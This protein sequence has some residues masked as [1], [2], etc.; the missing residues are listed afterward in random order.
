MH[1]LSWIKDLL[2]FPDTF[3]TQVSLEKENLN[4]PA[5][6]IGIAGVLKCISMVILLLTAGD[7]L[8]LLLPTAVIWSLAQPF[9]V[10]VVFSLVLQVLSNRLSGTGT[11]R[12]TLQNVGYGM[13]PWTFSQIFGI[14][15][16]LFLIHNSGSLESLQGMQSLTSF[17]GL[18]S[19]FSVLGFALLVWTGYLWVYGLKHAH[20]ITT[21]KAALAVI[22]LLAVYFLVTLGPVLLMYFMTGFYPGT[23]SPVYPQAGN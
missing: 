5:A 4:P 8:I 13:L 23:L 10:W 2:F 7:Y 12:L 18:L 6:I 14:L 19:I 20:Q 15:T 16:T 3:F 22:I 11:F 17:G 9:L 1:M 21:G